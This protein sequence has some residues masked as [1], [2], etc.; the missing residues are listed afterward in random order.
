MKVRIRRELAACEYSL[1]ISSPFHVATSF[2]L[3]VCISG[4]RLIDCPRRTPYNTCLFV[5]RLSRPV[6]PH[7]E[8]GPPRRWSAGL[9]WDDCWDL[10]RLKILTVGKL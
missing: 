7:L 6:F 1:T 10:V 4:N 5:R 9:R 8:L 2:S 3:V